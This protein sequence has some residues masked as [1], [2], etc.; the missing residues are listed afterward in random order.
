VMS[1]MR[2]TPPTVAIHDAATAALMCLSCM[3][4]K[5]YAA[6]MRRGCSRLHTRPPSVGPVSAAPQAPEMRPA[7]LGRGEPVAVEWVSLPAFLS[8]AAIP[9]SSPLQSDSRRPCVPFQLHQ[10][11]HTTRFS[12][13]YGVTAVLPLLQG[14]VDC[15]D[16]EEP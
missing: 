11:T 16:G 1:A 7:F 15:V 14:P 3:I 13:G 10:R 5:V 8:P 12:P 4:I 2:P 9:A 6:W